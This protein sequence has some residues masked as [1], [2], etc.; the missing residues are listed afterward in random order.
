M[1]AVVLTSERPRLEVAEV[2]D[3]VAGP[4]EVVLDVTGCGICGSDLHI[5]AVVGAEGG[6]LGHE[7][8]GRIAAHGAGVDAGAWPVGTA[9]A[10]RPLAGCGQCSWCEAGRPDHCRDFALIGLARTGGFAEQVVVQAREL[11][12]LPASLTP[13]EQVLVEPLAVARRAIRRAGLEAGDS[14][15][16]LGAGPIGLAVVAWASA[17]GV[18][19]LV[20]SEPAPIRRDLATRLG[21][22][23]VVDPARHD[24]AAV[25][26]EATGGA[27][28]SVV[29]EC[30]GRRGMIQAGAEL[31]AVEGRVVVAGI[32]LSTDEL[33][34]YTS[35]E[36]ELDLRFAVYY[37]RD[38][39]T[40]TL[41]A[42]DRGTLEP[43]VMVT[44]TVD[45]DGL[46]ERFA[47][48]DRDTDGGKVVVR[49]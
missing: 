5:A 9:V 48:L 27:G 12:R 35:I 14:V 2:P 38:D 37:G 41:D 10:A 21:A 28:P 44:D 39:F 6:V 42:L 20:A 18:G 33:F 11:F 1:R 26:A 43:D 8:A 4:G 19:T 47:R 16:V 32:C 24:L 17:M 31:A 29:F 46:P 45:L 34:P 40:D 3:A 30:S 23:A 7:I 15:V 13:D 36:K 22:T 25:A 49:P